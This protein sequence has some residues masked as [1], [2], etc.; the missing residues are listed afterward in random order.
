MKAAAHD[1]VG[2]RV[3]ER[4]GSGRR[5]AC[6]AVLRRGCVASATQR[7]AEDQQLKD[8]ER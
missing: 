5:L 7:R 2:G 1:R 4:D 3:V 8:R 6:G